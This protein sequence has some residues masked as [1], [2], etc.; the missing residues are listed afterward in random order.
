MSTLE[1]A[2]LVAIVA[3]AVAIV[4]LIRRDRSTRADADLIELW[5]VAFDSSPIA[6]LIKQNGVYVHCNPACVRILGARDRSHVLEVGPA[7]VAAE[8]QPDGRLTADVLKDCAEALKEGKTFQHQ[9][10]A[11]RTLDKDEPL[12]VDM[13][14]VP[15]KYRGDIALLSYIVDA[16]DRIRIANEARQ[17][18]QQIARNF[19]TT[20]G[21]LVQSLA[22]TAAEMRSA[23]QDMSKT[24]ED[25]SAQASSVLTR[26]EEAS[27]NVQVV[28]AATEELS[29]SVSEIGRQVTQ[30]TEIASQAVQEANRTNTTVQGLSMA[31]QK[32][33]DVV[34]L[35]SDIASQTN[36]LA[37]NATIEAARAGD[38][39][40]GFAV[41]ASEVK[42]LANQTAKATED[43]SAQVAA[44]Q[45]ATGG[46][47]DAIKNIGGTIGAMNEITMTIAA[48]IEEQGA[49]TQE[50]ARNVQA[51]AS[52]TDQMTNS[53]GGVTR[54][55]GQAGTAASQVV[56]LADRLGG[57]AETLRT[58]VK[59][60][61]AT[62]HAA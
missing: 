50:I 19:E 32:I 22:S 36:L 57:Q 17:Q 37:L 15:A 28:A 55:A 10:F 62:I 56:V 9:G 46:V 35:I 54:A 7:K 8:R 34:K 24:A 6:M 11:G 29:S 30:S 33:N 27:A 53:V 12:Y 13:Y 45:S 20:I 1:I 5:R 61:L 38:A 43:I 44:M 14:W 26:V 4:F 31:A 58:N 60:F 2:G 59:N 40:K 39:G 49:A 3:M 41:V 23:S 47:V 48:S 42:S 18:S 52:G 51:T 16:S 21:G 25:A